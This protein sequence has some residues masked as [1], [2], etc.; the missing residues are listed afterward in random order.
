[1]ATANNSTA[2]ANN[3][4]SATQM[5]V[6]TFKKLY[7]SVSAYNVDN[8][9]DFLD[10]E[11]CIA[12][13]N[14]LDE[15]FDTTPTAQPQATVETVETVQIIE[16]EKVSVTPTDIVLRDDQKGSDIVKPVRG[17]IKTAIFAIFQDVVNAGTPATKENVSIF[18]RAVEKQLPDRKGMGA[19]GNLFAEFRGEPYKKGDSTGERTTAQKSKYTEPKMDTTKL[20]ELVMAGDMDAVLALKSEHEKAVSQYAIDTANEKA[21]QQKAQ[22]AKLD[23][24]VTS[25]CSDLCRIFGDVETA[26]TE[27]FSLITSYFLALQNATA[28]TTEA[29][30]GDEQVL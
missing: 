15:I 9:T 27:A 1:M 6:A 8:D 11:E 24:K 30:S 28:Q 12:H 19:N 21:E 22:A 13:A 25:L 23:N 2:T 26:Q 14:G 4:T 16:S 20:M 17:A 29:T 3:N 18:I 5:T 7:G 10:R